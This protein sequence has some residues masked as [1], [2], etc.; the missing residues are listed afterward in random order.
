[1]ISWRPIAFIRT[2]IIRWRANRRLNFNAVADVSTTT[3]NQPFISSQISEPE[4]AR[5]TS[6][7]RRIEIITPGMNRYGSEEVLRELD[8]QSGL[9]DM[10]VR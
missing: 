5:T 8:T 7:S 1:M 10:D 9:T 6:S 2:R 4:I 3:N